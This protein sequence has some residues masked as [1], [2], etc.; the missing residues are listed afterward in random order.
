MDVQLHLSDGYMKYI[1]NLVL[2]NH[3]K[4]LLP[5]HCHGLRFCYVCTVCVPTLS[6]TRIENLNYNLTFE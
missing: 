5:V 4:K 6:C 3:R 1:F 2:L